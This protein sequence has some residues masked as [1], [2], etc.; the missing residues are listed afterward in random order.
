MKKSAV[1]AINLTIALATLTF[2]LLSLDSLS[3]Q[4]DS[5]KIDYLPLLAALV[6]FLTSHLFRSLRLKAINFAEGQSLRSIFAVS[7]LHNVIAYFLPARTGEISLLWFSK[8]I[9]ETPVHISSATLLSTRAY[10]LVILFALSFIAMTQSDMIN[11]PA[12][13]TTLAILA[14]ISCVAIMILFLLKK[15]AVIS[16]VNTS[17]THSIMRFA[18]TLL[19]QL[20]HRTAPVMLLLTA[21]IWCCVI[22]N[23]YSICLA[24]G[25][26]PQLMEMALISI[27]AL[28]LSLLPVNGVANLGSHEAAWVMVLSLLGAP[29]EQSWYIAVGSHVILIVFIITLSFLAISVLLYEKKITGRKKIFGS[30]R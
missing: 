27:V 1:I 20:H 14:M 22:L 30:R 12:L 4:W 24:L 5:F 26:K 19:A 10:D 6:F 16:S 8:Q 9:L 15:N 3:L 11:I 28:P 23:F 18:D 17:R 21:L 7:S 25:F 29:K 2:I 13:F